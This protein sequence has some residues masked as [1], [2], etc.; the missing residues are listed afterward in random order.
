MKS[1]L[2]P[3]HILFAEGPRR[4]D[5]LLQITK[6]S[7][8]LPWGFSPFRLEEEQIFTQHSGYSWGELL[9]SPW[10]MNNYTTSCLCATFTHTSLTYFRV[11]HFNPEDSTR[12]QIMPWV[13][14]VFNS[15]LIR[16]SF[17]H[18]SSHNQELRQFSFASSWTIKLG[19][20]I[21]PSFFCFRLYKGKGDQINI[22]VPPYSYNLF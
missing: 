5:R 16:H 18:L 11:A 14:L 21:F 19:N 9:T 10:F 3:F 15:T 13:P 20:L 8:Y 6:D 7:D 22:C 17:L 12:Q 2:F 1:A 4:A